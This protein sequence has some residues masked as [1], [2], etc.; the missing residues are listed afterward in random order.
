MNI[1]IWLVM[2]A[3]LGWVASLLMR[4]DARQGLITNVVVGVVGALLGGWIVGPMIGGGNINQGDFSAKSLL[5]SLLGAVVLLAIVNLLSR[6]R[7][8]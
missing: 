4:T 1:V 5:V 6:A 2:G 7:A 8:R 3:I